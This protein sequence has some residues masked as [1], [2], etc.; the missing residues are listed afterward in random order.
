MSVA[1]YTANSLAEFVEQICN[2]N[3]QLIKN[4][5]DR[6]EIPLFRGQASV[7]YELIPSLGRNQRHL[8]SQGLQK[9]LFDEERN[10][11]EMAKYRLPDLFRNDMQPLELLA[12]L[13]HYGIPTR[14]LDIT[15]NAL[16][17]LYFACCS[18]PDKDG[19]VFVFKYNELDVTIYPLAHAIADSYRF[20]HTPC[21]VSHFF[22]MIN[23]Q[24]Y[25]TEEHG[26]RH[27][28]GSLGGYWIAKACY[29][30]VFCV[31]APIRSERQRAQKGRYILFPNKIILPDKNNPS[32]QSEPMMLPMLEPIDKESDSVIFARIHIPHN[33]KYS[34]LKNLSLLGI[35]KEFLFSDDIGAVC[36][37]IKNT[38]LQKINQV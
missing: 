8:E 23:E 13:Q 32:N 29:N 28:S 20:A 4:G 2:L 7:D 15:E 3:N 24:P 38:F 6:N 21:T 1:H 16:V 19:E 25:F 26:A 33:I 9:G 18:E 34:I 12:L 5:N 22:S 37:G 17:A 35:D 11:I 14:L 36:S 30:S 31:H 10:L 27:G